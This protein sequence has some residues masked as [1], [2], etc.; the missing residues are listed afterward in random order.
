MQ[1]RRARHLCQPL[2]R[3]L[4]VLA[5]DHHQVGHLVDDDDDIGQRIEVE[6]LVLVDRLAGLL[7]EARVHGAREILALG[8]GFDQAGIVAVDIA[9]A[10]LGHALV[11]LLHLAHR[12]FQR[13]HRLLGIGDDGG[14]E[15]RD[16]V[17]DGELE[18]LRIDH[19]QA[20]LI[21]TQR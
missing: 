9:H 18:H 13:D 16:A 14:Q 8:P 10:E 7:V 4:D 11:A 19:D 3:A 20:A 21:G 5:G 12:P 2:H 6:L 1:P 15:M 17:I